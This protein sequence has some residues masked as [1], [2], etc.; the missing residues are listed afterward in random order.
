MNKKF[1][2]VETVNDVTLCLFHI[3]VSRGDVLII[4]KSWNTDY[5]V[6]VSVECLTKKNFITDT[7][8]FVCKLNKKVKGF[9]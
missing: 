7:F 9:N 2:M 3:Y 6:V 8:K 5:T 1:S 4:L